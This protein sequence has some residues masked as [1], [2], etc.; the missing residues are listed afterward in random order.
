[1]GLDRWIGVSWICV[2]VWFCVLKSVLE[3]EGDREEKEYK[4]R[5]SKKRKNKIEYLNK[6]GKK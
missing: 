4:K 1:M 5:N 3:V 6:M 2:C